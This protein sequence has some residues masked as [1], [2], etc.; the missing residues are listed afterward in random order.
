MI[1]ATSDPVAVLFDR[2]ACRSCA[3]LKPEADRQNKAAIV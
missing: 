2:M 1:I 3:L